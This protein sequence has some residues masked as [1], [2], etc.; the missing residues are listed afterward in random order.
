MVWNKEQNVDIPSYKEISHLMRA[1]FQK[2]KCFLLSYNWLQKIL[3]T[4]MLFS[5]HFHPPHL[6]MGLGTVCENESLLR[7]GERKNCCHVCSKSLSQEEERKEK[8]NFNLK[9]V[10]MLK[11]F[12]APSL[13]A[14]LK[15]PSI[16][17]CL[18]SLS[19]KREK[20]RRKRKPYLK[21]LSW[22]KSLYVGEIYPH[23]GKR[24]NLAKVVDI[25]GQEERKNKI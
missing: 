24:Y 8:K 14:L 22:Q 5:L 2:E 10:F 13:K 7:M 21:I 9:L 4:R 17:I 15:R 12:F 11:Q 16:Q 18:I 20:K 3:F 1:I 23:S 19:E 25:H 6:G